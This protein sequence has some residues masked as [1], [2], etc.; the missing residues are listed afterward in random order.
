V[1]EVIINALPDKDLH[2]QL[3]WSTPSDPHENDEFGTDVDLHF[4]H[5]RAGDGWGEGAQSFDCYFRNKTPEWGVPGPADN[6]TL[7][8][9][10]TNGAGPENVNL[11]EPEIGVSYDIGAIYFR[12]Q[13]TFGDPM[14]DRRLE[15]ASYVTVRLYARGELILEF[16]AK[17][18]TGLRQLWHVATLTWCEDGD[19]LQRC[20]EIQEEDRL[21]TEAEY[22]SQ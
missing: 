15:H 22:R 20:P 16:L 19:D 3:V 14:A 12:T 17:E 21:Y 8:I 11:G 1:A 7:D 6:P 4:R 10:D 18:M 13:S 5:E 9:D 2:I